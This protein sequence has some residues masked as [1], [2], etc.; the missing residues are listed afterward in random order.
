MCGRLERSS[1]ARDRDRSLSLPDAQGIK[2]PFPPSQEGNAAAAADLGGGAERDSGTGLLGG[3]DFVDDGSSSGFESDASSFVSDE[4][5]KYSMAEF[6]S[7]AE[8]QGAGIHHT[9]CR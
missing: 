6:R 3:E 1:K 2:V 9:R 5:F 7:C 4:R 8:V